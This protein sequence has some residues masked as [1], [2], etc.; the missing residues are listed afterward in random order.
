MRT[1][2]FAQV[3]LCSLLLATAALPNDLP[4]RHCEC[5]P[6]DQGQTGRTGPRGDEGPEGPVGE[7]GRGGEKGETGDR[8]PDGPPGG[9]ITSFCPV[10]Q[11][12][13]FATIPIPPCGDPAI[14]GTTN[15]MAFNSVNGN[16]TI[17]FPFGGTWVVTAT[18]ETFDFSTAVPVIVALSTSQVKIELPPNAS[19]VDVFATTCTA[20]DLNQPSSN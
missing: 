5:I 1:I 18:A 13:L 3:A 9:N 15:G 4:A 11:S 2:N 6:G 7:T 20:P 16:V 19:A 14:T 12:L 10:T 17:T 8:G